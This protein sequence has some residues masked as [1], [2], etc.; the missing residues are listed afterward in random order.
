MTFQESF[1]SPRKREIIMITLDAPVDEL[2][3]QLKFGMVD[4]NPVSNSSLMKY[5]KGATPGAVHT[6][7]TKDNAICTRQWRLQRRLLSRCL[8]MLNAKNIEP[9]RFP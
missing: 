7:F 4:L 3:R 2:V 9:P 8:E 6:I 5:V 1:Y